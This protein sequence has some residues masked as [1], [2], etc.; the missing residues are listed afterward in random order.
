MSE[1]DAEDGLHGLDEPLARRNARGSILNLFLHPNGSHTRYVSRLPPPRRPFNFQ[2]PPR[3][4]CA[5]LPACGGEDWRRGGGGHG[6]ESDHSRTKPPRARSARRQFSRSKKV[7]T[8]S[9]NVAS[10]RKRAPCPTPPDGGCQSLIHRSTV[11]SP[12]RC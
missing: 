7:R 4:R 6:V 8:W 3:N 2:K 11:D 1:A 10:E 9:Y 5:C 12:M